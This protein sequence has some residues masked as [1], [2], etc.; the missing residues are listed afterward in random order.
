MEYIDI[1]EVY[2]IHEQILRVSKGRSGVRDFALLH[3]AIERPRAT[4]AGE[5]LYPTVFAKA[6]ALMQS[7]CLN[8]AFFDA[9]KRTA[10]ATTKWFLALNKYHLHANVKEAADFMVY[11]DNDKPD[12]LEIMQWLKMHSIE[13][14]Q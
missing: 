4:Y 5:D 6:A 7:L 9:N 8:H 10:W 13:H 11:V 12:F 14:G 2:R 3:S 1:K